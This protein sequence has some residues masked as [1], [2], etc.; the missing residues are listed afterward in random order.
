MKR[1]LLTAAVLM[2]CSCS[3]GTSAPQ[4]VTVVSSE[5]TQSVTEAVTETETTAETTSDTTTEAVSETTE[6]EYVPVYPDFEDTPENAYERLTISFRDGKGNETAPDDYAGAYSYFGKMYIC[7]TEK[8]PSSYYTDLLGEY[9]CIS[10]KTVTHSFNELTE[11]ARQASAELEG[12]YPVTDVF[13]DVPS[14]KAAVNIAEGDPKE[15]RTYLEEREFPVD[16]LVITI[17]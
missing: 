12:K 7:I 15:I 4:T 5:T 10:Y 16:L 3:Q 1:I 13:V 8:E 11:I 6:T 2:L 9:T 14:N 17:G